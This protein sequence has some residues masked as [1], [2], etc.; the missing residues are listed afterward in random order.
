M[1][2]KLYKGWTEGIKIMSKVPHLTCYCEPDYADKPYC[3]DMEAA[4]GNG[5][6]FA[7]PEEAG[8]FVAEWLR[9]HVAPPNPDEDEGGEPTTR[10]LNHYR[11]VCGHEWTDEWDCMCNDRCPKC[12][13]EIEPYQSDELAVNGMQAVSPPCGEYVSVWDG[14]QELHSRCTVNLVARTVEIEEC[15][16]ADVDSLEEEYVLLDGVKYPAANEADRDQ[17]TADEQAGMFFYD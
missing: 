17:Y 4:D 11:C 6:R 1:S 12:D 2:V 5:R 15:H 9:S 7:T 16:E 10:Y 8:K 13:T 3:V 14:G